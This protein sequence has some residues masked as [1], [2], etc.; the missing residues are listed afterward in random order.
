[1]TVVNT[2]EDTHAQHAD[3]RLTLSCAEAEHLRLALPWLLRALEDRPAA[4]PRQRER[5]RTAHTAL[6]RLQVALSSQLHEAEEGRHRATLV[7][8]GD[9]G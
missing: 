6:D 2:S 8:I 4:S 5:R 3:V 7:D 1:M 9:N